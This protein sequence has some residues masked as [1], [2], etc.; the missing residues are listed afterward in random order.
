MTIHVWIV[1][2]FLHMDKAVGRL[3]S[4]RGGRTGRCCFPFS[5]RIEFDM[6]QPIRSRGEEKASSELLDAL[7][8]GIGKSG[9][10]LVFF[11]FALPV[12]PSSGAKKKGSRRQGGAFQ[13]SFRY[14][15][16]LC[17]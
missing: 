13:W 2:V 6:P 3:H 14:L 8:V 7:D 12:I 16:K 5:E 1:F 15:T 11:G 4:P 17:M 9:I 10:I